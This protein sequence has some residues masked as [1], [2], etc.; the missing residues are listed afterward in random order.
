MT[1]W[2]NFNA[3][4]PTVKHLSGSAHHSHLQHAS[5]TA[6][7]RDQRPSVFFSPKLKFY[8]EYGYTL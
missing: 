4:Y 8:L 6:H 2:I 7:A 3:K 5:C 1:S